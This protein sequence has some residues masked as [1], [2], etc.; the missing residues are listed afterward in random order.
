MVRGVI[1]WEALDVAEAVGASAGG[2]GGSQG[3][4]RSVV[5]GSEGVTTTGS[6]EKSGL[7]VAAHEDW[8]RD[9]L[10]SWRQQKVEEACSHG[11]PRSGWGTGVVRWV[12]TRLEWQFSMLFRQSRTSSLP[13][14][15]KTTTNTAPLVSVPRGPYPPLLSTP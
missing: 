4:S 6:L 12:A 15:F 10:L 14:A 13:R 11:G 3:G 7:S 9:E 8:E 5:G 1:D 2:N